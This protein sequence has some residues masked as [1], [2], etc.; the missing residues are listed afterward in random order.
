MNV[1]IPQQ[2]N[3]LAGVVRI[4]NSV[5]IPL[6]FQSFQVR[7]MLPQTDHDLI[8]VYTGGHLQKPPIGSTDDHCSAKIFILNLLVQIFLIGR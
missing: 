4:S 1:T 3:K 7:T 6:N 8:N 2:V 5:W